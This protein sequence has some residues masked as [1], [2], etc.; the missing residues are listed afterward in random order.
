MNKQ[1]DSEELYRRIY[2]IVNGGSALFA[3]IAGPFGIQRG[4]KEELLKHGS[5]ISAKIA[6]E[7]LLPEDVN[8]FF[9]LCQV[10][11]ANSVMSQSDVDALM[12]ILERNS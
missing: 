1:S 8:A 10:S 11:H 6:K 2:E 7:E 4:L 3:G 9:G 5:I 12:L